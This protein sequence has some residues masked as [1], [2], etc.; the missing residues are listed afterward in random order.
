[1]PQIVQEDVRPA[2]R[3]PPALPH[4]VESARNHRPSVIRSKQP[5]FR[6][7]VDEVL[8]MVFDAGEDVSRYGQAAGPGGSLR[9]S[10]DRRSLHG[11][12]D[13]PLN[14]HRSVEQI[15]VFALEPKYLA[16]P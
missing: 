1:M 3:P 4:T 6:L 15:D 7:S 8:Q 11:P 2:D 9:R 5:R 14:S 10:D 16:T 13:G 12:N